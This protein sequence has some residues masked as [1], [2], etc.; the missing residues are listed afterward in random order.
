[1]SA[2]S[3][4]EKTA[5]RDPRDIASAEDLDEF[6]SGRREKKRRNKRKHVT[7]GRSVFLLQELAARPKERK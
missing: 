1:M 5:S 4:Y 7:T 2:K 6:R 3:W